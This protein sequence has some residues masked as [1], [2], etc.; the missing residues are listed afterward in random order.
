M[1]DL[2]LTRIRL[3]LAEVVL[4]FADESSEGK[5][6]VSEEGGTSKEST[7]DTVN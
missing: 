7:Y 3:F 5:A 2:A 1:K 4:I 6:L